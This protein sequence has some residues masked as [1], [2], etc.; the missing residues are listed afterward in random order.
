[1][2]HFNVFFLYGNFA[3]NFSIPP[4]FNPKNFVFAKHPKYDGA[5]LYSELKRR[6]VDYIIVMPTIYQKNEYLKRWLR[7]GSTTDFIASMEKRWHE[8]IRSCEKDDA[9][10]IYLDENEYIS[11]VL[12][13]I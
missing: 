1:M 12:P 3:I 5:M 13:M 4:L 2:Q 11:D 9:P 8:M 6:G 7:R 10:K